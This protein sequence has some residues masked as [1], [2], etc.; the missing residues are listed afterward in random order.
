[1]STN[2]PEFYQAPKFSPE[3]DQPALPKQHGCFFYGCIIASI[4]ALLMVILVAIV[5]YLFCRFASA[6]IEQYTS[7]TPRELPK[8]DMPP[9]QRQALKD[10]VE[11]FRKAVE[12]GSRPSPWS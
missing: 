3:P 2:D 6:A 12:K 4:L 7:T 5:S 8:V 11:A 10:R 1:M 9:E